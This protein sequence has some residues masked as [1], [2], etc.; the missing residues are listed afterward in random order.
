MKMHVQLTAKTPL[1]IGLLAFIVLALAGAYLVWDKSIMLATSPVSDKERS[2]A[3]GLINRKIEE[4]EKSSLT[5]KECKHKLIAYA[6]T[7]PAVGAVDASD[8]NITIFFKDRIG[9]TS[10]LTKE[11]GRDSLCV[12]KNLQPQT[13]R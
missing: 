3:L 12:H 10:I 5:S 4:L 7:I 9:D 13:E 11:F 8:S 1:L 6:K 2:E